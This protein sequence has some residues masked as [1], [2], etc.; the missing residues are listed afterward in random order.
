MWTSKT[1]LPFMAIRGHWINSEWKLED[2]LMDF[3]CVE[4]SHD[5]KSL[6][7]SYIKSTKNVFLSFQK[8]LAFTMDNATNNDTFMDS[9]E[10]ETLE[11]DCP[12]TKENNRIRCLAHVV[13]LVAQD[14]LGDLGISSNELQE[15]D[16]V[17]DQEIEQEIESDDEECSPENTDE[18][19]DSNDE[20][21][22]SEPS[23]ASVMNKIRIL[24]KKIR[25]S[26]QLRQ[27]LK[28][29]CLFHK[30]KPLCPII[31]VKTRW[32]STFFMIERAEFLKVPLLSLCSSKKKL[33]SYIVCESEWNILKKVQILLRKFHQVT[34]RAS[35]S[36]DSTISGYI[37]T[38]HWLMDSIDDFK[39]N[40]E[41][42]LQNAAAV[43]RQKLM[44]YLPTIQTSPV[45]FIATILDPKLKL[46]Y[47]KEQKYSNRDLKKIKD[48]FSSA[49]KSHYELMD[50]SHSEQSSDESGDEFL[51]HM[52][53]RS[54]KESH[55]NELTI[56]FQGPL[57]YKKC[58]ILD[59]WQSKESELPGLSKM[60]KDYLAI[61]SSSVGVE[62]TFAGAVDLVVPTRASLSP[63]VIT[64]AMCLKSWWRD[65]DTITEV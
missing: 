4:G 27:E 9:L 2:I 18:D 26:P 46:N 29:H 53:K 33:N 30:V 65:E 60:A 50:S 11:F 57:A 41:G 32:N 16:S 19:S 8:T 59:W 43:A 37:P 22:S 6:C 39:K 31:D 49:F 62:R 63:P 40:N 61:P 51:S 48:T 56:Y 34:L 13:N 42:S 58:K 14:F 35:Q 47:F 17:P 20:D 1:G 12:L 15:P 64:A 10:T 3:V 44:K 55:A 23:T 25:K 54:K 5:G 45:T 52:T 21:I 38:F 24:V 28:K 36:N 7:S